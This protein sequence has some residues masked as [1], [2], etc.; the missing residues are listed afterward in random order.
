MN[1]LIAKSCSEIG[2]VNRTLN[3]T[4]GCVL[5]VH[6]FCFEAKVSSLELK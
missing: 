5:D 3:S 2:R 1:Q 4:S 6:L